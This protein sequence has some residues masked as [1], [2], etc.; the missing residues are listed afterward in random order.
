M[1]GG[2][3]WLREENVVSLDSISKF[4]GE[5]NDAKRA[6]IV[7]KV[8]GKESLV[9]VNFTNKGKTM[10]I[11]VDKNLLLL[12]LSSSSIVMDVAGQSTMHEARVDDA[13]G[14][15]LPDDKKKRR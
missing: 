15:E 8:A 10:L 1:M 6:R 2:E 11:G 7:N 5:R 9:Y 12:R 13:Y 14:L 3:R 4:L